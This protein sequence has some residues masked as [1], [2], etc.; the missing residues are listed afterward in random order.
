M[1]FSARSTERGTTLLEVSIGSALLAS[2]IGLALGQIGESADAT[3]AVTAQ[4]DLRRTA[5]GVL[6]RLSRDLRSTQ[7]RFVSAQGG[8]IE[9]YKVVDYDP[10][11]DVPLVESPLGKV[12]PP[13]GQGLFQGR[14]VPRV[15]RILGALDRAAPLGEPAPGADDERRAAVR[16]CLHALAAIGT[17]DASGVL[18]ERLR[19]ASRSEI[20]EALGR[21]KA[22]ADRADLDVARQLLD[23]ME[24]A[25]CPL[26]ERAEIGNALRSLLRQ[27]FGTNAAA[28]RAHLQRV[29]AS[30]RGGAP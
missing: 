22:K 8:A 10:D 5:E 12:P 17:A 14:L 6:E 19:W 30:R 18:L 11:G 1:R 13:D 23:R 25:E 26:A 24:A 28:W 27:T 21:V 7:A 15:E 29:V 2:V 3:K 20:I 4:A 16:A 9:L